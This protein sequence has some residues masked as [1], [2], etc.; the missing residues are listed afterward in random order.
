MEPL[1]DLV[2]DRGRGHSLIRDRNRNP[3]QPDPT[4]AL[5]DA[6]EGD[7]KRYGKR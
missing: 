1:E 4:V 3:P 5:E 7:G 2:L 6:A